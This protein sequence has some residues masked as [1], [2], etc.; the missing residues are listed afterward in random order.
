MFFKTYATTRFDAY[1]SGMH[2][3]R[4]KTYDYVYATYEFFSFFRSPYP[5]MDVV[6]P[7]LA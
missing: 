1:S 7:V 2:G 4:G 3:F 6:S 5:A